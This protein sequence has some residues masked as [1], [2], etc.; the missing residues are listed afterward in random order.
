MYIITTLI[1]QLMNSTD[2]YLN[3]QLVQYVTSCNLLS[4]AWYLTLNDRSRGEQWILFPENLNVSQD[5]VEGNIEI[6]RKQNSLFP[7]GPVIKW[8]VTWQNK[9]KAKFENRAEI[10]AIT[11]RLTS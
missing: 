11:S 3:K 2:N 7:K 1:I 5:E 10:P 9:T 6:R 4:K 8:F